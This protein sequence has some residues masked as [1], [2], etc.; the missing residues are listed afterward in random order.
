MCETF[1]DSL[2]VTSSTL[3]DV[4]NKKFSQV[5][6]LKMI[7]CA[8]SFSLLITNCDTF[9]GGAFHLLLLLA[10]RCELNVDC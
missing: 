7:Y 3:K 4:T 5:Q 9:D 1:N 2:R 10:L 8:K 6:I